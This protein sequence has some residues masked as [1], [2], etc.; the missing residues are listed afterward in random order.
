MTGQDDV[1][2]YLIAEE[3]EIDPQDKWGSTPLILSARYNNPYT[4]KVGLLN[5]SSTRTA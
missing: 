2:K 5:N 4:A 1:I 3:C